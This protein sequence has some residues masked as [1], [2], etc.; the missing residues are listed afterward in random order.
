MGTS[1]K[2]IDCILQK[3]LNVTIKNPVI[4]IPFSQRLPPANRKSNIYKFTLQ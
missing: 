1:Y 2:A 3:D 4:R